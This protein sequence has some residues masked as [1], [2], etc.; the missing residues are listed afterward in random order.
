MELFATT[1]YVFLKFHVWGRFACL[2]FVIKESP[3]WGMFYEN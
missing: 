3:D 1:G 2:A